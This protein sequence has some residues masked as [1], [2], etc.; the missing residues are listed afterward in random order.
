MEETTVNVWGRREG[1]ARGGGGEGEG[2]NDSAL[3]GELIGDSQHSFTLFH[4]A[5]MLSLCIAMETENG[6]ALFNVS[7]CTYYVGG[8]DQRLNVSE[9]SHL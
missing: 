3:S 9:G 5:E 8:L 6:W 2:G 4:I 1:N 7:S